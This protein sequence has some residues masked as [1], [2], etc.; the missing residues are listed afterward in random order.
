MAMNAKW[1]F[2]IACVSSLVC[3]LLGGMQE[4]PPISGARLPNRFSHTPGSNRHYG[5]ADK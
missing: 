4:K 5:P 2:M 1:L 3:G